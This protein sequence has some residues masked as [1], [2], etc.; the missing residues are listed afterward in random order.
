MPPTLRPSSRRPAILLTAAFVLPA[1][2]AADWPQWRGP[3]R[4]GKSPETGLLQSWPEGGPPLAWKATGLGAGFSSVAV[5]GERIYTLGD[6]GDAQYAIALARDGGGLVWKTPIGPA[7]NDE[8]LGPRST[9]T[10]DGD[11]VYVLGT[12]GE[13]HCLEAATGVKVWSRS[14]TKE[15]GGK[16]MSIKGTDWKFSESPLVDGDRVI[17]TPGAK[18]A[19]LAALD[20]RTGKETWRTALPAQLGERG[21]DGAAYSSIVISKGAGVKQYVQLLGRGAVGVDAESGRFLWG[22][23]RIANDVANIPTPLVDGDRVFVSTGYGTGAALLELRKTEGGVAATEVYFLDPDT[24]Q[25][26]HGGMILHGGHVYSGTAHNKGLPL[27]VELATG[28]VAWGPVRNAGTG[29][30]AV[31][32]GDGRL[33]LRYQNGLVL[34]VEA[35]PE[36]YREHGSITLADVTHPSWPHPVISGGRLYLR[37]QDALYCYDIARPAPEVTSRT[38]PPAR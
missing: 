10:V 30:A 3:G 7:W 6:Y 26:H 38:A 8:F 37:E 12:E 20:K 28:K 31:A 27:A 17:V 5:A 19:A 4:D 13:L 23:N 14:L 24:M 16:M 33:Y 34:L 25:N 2:N 32:Y 18:D 36:A 11:R 21:A 22:Y 15:F 35:T 9:P 1:T 29:S